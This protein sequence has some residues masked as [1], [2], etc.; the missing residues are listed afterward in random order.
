MSDDRFNERD[1]DLNWI[2]ERMLLDPPPAP[3]RRS[4]MAYLRHTNTKTL[5]TRWLP[6]GC[7]QRIIQIC[8]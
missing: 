6:N 1:H 7:V 8:S 5:L 3:Q 4:N 2:M